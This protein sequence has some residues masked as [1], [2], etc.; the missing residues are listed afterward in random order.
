VT[1][2]AAPAATPT[3]ATGEMDPL[4]PIEVDISGTSTYERGDEIHVVIKT[5][6]GSSCEM[7]VKWPDGNLADEDPKTADSRGRCEYK[8]KIPSKTAIGVGTLTGTVRNGGR[9]STQIVEYQVVEN[10]S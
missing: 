5:P 8:I 1:A 9:T 4:L 7:N 2:A 6:A 3:G 10:I